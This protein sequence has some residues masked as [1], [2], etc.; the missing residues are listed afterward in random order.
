MFADPTL[1]YFILGLPLIAWPAKYILSF[2]SS[3]LGLWKVTGDDRITVDVGTINRLDKANNM[4]RLLKN[5][6]TNPFRN[7]FIL[8]NREWLVNNLATILGGRN[9][10]A[11]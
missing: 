9:Y 2:V 6:T 10:G 11:R 7:K 3:T 1:P 4:K 8:V 5:I